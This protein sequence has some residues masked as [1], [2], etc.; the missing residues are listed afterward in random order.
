MRTFLSL[1]TV[2]AV[3]VGCGDNN[4]P[5]TRDNGILVITAEQDLETTEAGGTATFQV[6]LN[7]P[8]YGRTLTVDLTSLDLTEGTVSPASI[9]FT[10]ANWQTPVTVTVTGVD[11]DV[12]DGSKGYPVH[13]TAGQT[14][15]VR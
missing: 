10:H 1:L 9:E 13:V 11:D 8:P 4:I 2:A 12:D 15:T 3:A 6:A 5:P 7:A 14:T